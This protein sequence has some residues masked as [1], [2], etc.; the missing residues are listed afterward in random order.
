MFPDYKDNKRTDSNASIPPEREGF[1]LDAFLGDDLD[2]ESVS[3]VDVAL[4]GRD[5]DVL[6]QVDSLVLAQRHLLDTLHVLEPDLVVKERLEDGSGGPGGS[7]RLPLIGPDGV[8]TVNTALAF[9]V[10]TSNDVVH[11]VGEESS[12]VQHRGHHGGY[13]PRTH[14]RVV[15]VLIHL[16]S[17]FYNFC[18]CEDIAME[19]STCQDGFVSE[20]STLWTI[21]GMN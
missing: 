2:L 6:D 5:E 11:I 14:L 13:R 21:S 20:L 7:V 1:Q 9:L 3:R 8:E 4:G 12:V 16:Q 15:F 10:Q 19:T 18:E 17:G